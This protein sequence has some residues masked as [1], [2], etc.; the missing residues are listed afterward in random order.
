MHECAEFREQLETAALERDG[1]ERLEAGD[2]PEAARVAGHLAF[3]PPCAEELARLRR[4]VGTL[5]AALAGGP[6]PVLR[7]RTLA[8]VRATGVERPAP[9]VVTELPPAGPGGRDAPIP[10]PTPGAVP[11]VVLPRR[12]SRSAVPA[13][14]AAVAAVLVVG[15]FGAGLLARGP[16]GPAVAP[17]VAPDPAL[18]QVAAAYTRIT[19]APDATEVMLA[20]AAGTPR[21]VLAIAPSAGQM[22]VTASGLP[23]APE[24][25]VYRCWAEIGGQRSVLGTMYFAGDVAWWAGP[26]V[27][28]GAIPPGSRFGVSLAGPGGS[29]AEPVLLGSS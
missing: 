4:T 10:G 17:T 28:A 5:R 11:G 20:D 13:W 18:A 6:P 26:V 29:V 16:A 12:T 3:C 23:P 15:A 25:S 14:L 9:G 22:V 2:T 7:E 24:G 27:L 21:G 1:I 19:A 8:L